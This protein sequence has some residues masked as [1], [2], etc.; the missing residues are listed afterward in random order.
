MQQAP[1]RIHNAKYQ[2]DTAFAFAE[3][4]LKVTYF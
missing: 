3:K 1:A 4:R 2:A